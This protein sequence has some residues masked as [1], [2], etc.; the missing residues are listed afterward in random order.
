VC[1][2]SAIRI[3]DAIINKLICIPIAL[4]CCIRYIE[5]SEYLGIV[6]LCQKH[7]DGT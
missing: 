1:M 3:N 4:F 2:K 6:H 5:L 7:A